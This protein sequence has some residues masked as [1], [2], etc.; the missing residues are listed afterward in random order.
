DAESGL[1]LDGSH[2]AVVLARDFGARFAVVQR[3]AFDSRDVR[4]ATWCRVLEGVPAAT[5]DAARRRLGLGTGGR[6]GVRRQYGGPFYSGPGPDPARAHDLASELVRLL[7]SNGHRR[8][9]RL[10][11]DEAVDAWLGAADVLVL[12]P[13]VLDKDT[14]RRRAGGALL[15]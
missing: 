4:V 3:V 9:V 6:E 12:R 1:I 13:P 2:R 10:V 11:E 8:P 5:F 15:P 7:S 14:V